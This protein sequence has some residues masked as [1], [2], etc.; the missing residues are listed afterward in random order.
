MSNRTPILLVIALVLVLAGILYLSRQ[1]EEQTGSIAWRV[2]QALLKVVPPTGT[3]EI[4]EP[5]WAGLTIRQL[6]HIAEYALLG[7]AAVL[8]TRWYWGRSP[9]TLVLATLIC[10]SIS[11]FDQ[12]LKI[13]IPGRHFDAQDLLLDA[14]GYLIVVVI[15]TI[16]P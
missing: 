3:G 8:V 7:V 9:T 11:L 4:G 14:G 1:G 16:L 10:A 12:L 5:T 13:Y 6:A 15:G 2:E